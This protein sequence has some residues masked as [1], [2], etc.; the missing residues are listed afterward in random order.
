[1][2]ALYLIDES[3]GVLKPAVVIGLP[4]EYVKG[5]GDIPLGEQCCGRAA[6]NNLPW[7]VE[8]IWNNPT[9]PADAREAARRAGV[10]AGF[11]VPVVNAQGMCIGSL[12]AHFCAPH[13]PSDHEIRN[14]CMFAQLVA[15]A[16][17]RDANRTKRPSSPAA[18]PPKDSDRPT[19]SGTQ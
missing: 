17:A 2:G 13:T 6:L 15:L 11:S 9:F 19:A 4:E 12:S 1:M 14:H 18:R 3:L 10:R 7:Y 8:D 16:L 5:C